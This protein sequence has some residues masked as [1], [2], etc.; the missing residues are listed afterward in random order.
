MKERRSRA[1]ARISYLLEEF[2]QRL[3]RKRLFCFPADQSDRMKLERIHHHCQQHGFIFNH[4]TIQMIR[5]S[6]STI[7]PDETHSRSSLDRSVETGFHLA[8]VSGLPDRIEQ[9]LFLVIELGHRKEDVPAYE[10]VHSRGA[11]LLK[12]IRNSRGTVLVD[13]LAIGLRQFLDEVRSSTM[14]NSL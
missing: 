8:H 4:S 7:M 3:D 2:S 11:M 13:Q 5:R 9:G 6:L 10:I 12:T 1:S 14:K